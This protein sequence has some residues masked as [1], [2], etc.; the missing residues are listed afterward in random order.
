M[1]KE[2]NKI[3][4][5]GEEVE[6]FNI[7]QKMDGTMEITYSKTFNIVNAHISNIH[8]RL[9]ENNLHCQV[10]KDFKHGIIS[11]WLNNINDLHGVLYTLKIPAGTYDVLYEDKIIVI[12]IPKLENNAR[13]TG[14]MKNG[15]EQ[16]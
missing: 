3:I 11:I 10:F 9:R 14:T 1:Q 5:N 6:Y 12:D 4:I 7:Q 15:V 8:K 13:I 2:A 16:V